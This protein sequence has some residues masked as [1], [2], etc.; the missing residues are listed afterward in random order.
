[1]KFFLLF[2]YTQLALWSLWWANQ[3]PVS[4]H[5]SWLKAKYIDV[6]RFAQET[7][8][9]HISTLMPTSNYGDATIH[10]PSDPSSEAGWIRDEFYTRLRMITGRR[11]YADLG[12]D[13]GWFAESDFVHHVSF[14]MS[15]VRESRHK[16]IQLIQ[17]FKAEADFD[18]VYL[19]D[20]RGYEFWI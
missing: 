4:I 3:P 13:E 19:K 6:V 16:L 9:D 11:V 5:E 1:M 20:C 14:T 12:I 2:L 7:L 17:Q 8:E 10:F 18:R 15:C